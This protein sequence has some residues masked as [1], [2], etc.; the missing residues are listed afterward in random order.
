MPRQSSR[1]GSSTMS[2]GPGPLSPALKAL[3]GANVAVFLAGSV[4]EWSSITWLPAPSASR[5]SVGRASRGLAARHLHVPARGL[6]HLLFNM[7]ALWMFGTELERIWG[8]RVLPEVLFRH[9]HRRRRADGRGVAAA[10]FSA[11]WYTRRSS[12]HR[13]RS[14]D[15]CSPT[16]LYFPDRP[17]YM[18]FVFPIPAK[19]F[20]MIMGAIA[21]YSSLNDNS[22]VANADASRRTARRLSV[23]EGR[24][25]PPAVGSEVLVSAVEDGADAQEVRR[26]LRRT[27]ER[28]EPAR[29]L[30]RCSRGPRYSRSRANVA[31]STDSAELD[32]ASHCG[33]D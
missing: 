17:I 3:I 32:V 29:P 30:E 28:L 18:Y 11:L 1:F 14:T 24:A 23:S 5:P 10:V 15:C 2:F 7:L 9:R 25:D 13:A 21:F 31:P 4:L 27:R 22:G 19:Y 33:R 16:A 6:F 8:T 26:L 20:V 12:A